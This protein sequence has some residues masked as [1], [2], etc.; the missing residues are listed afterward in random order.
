MLV[1]GLVNGTAV[2]FQVAAINAVGTG[3]FSALSNSVTPTTAAPVLTVPG[4]PGIGTAVAGNASATVNWTAPA[5]TGGS[6]ITGYSVRVVNAAN[7]QVGA[8]RPA[9]AGSTSLVVTV[10]NGTAVRFQ[11]AAV[12]AVGTGLFSAL[13]NAV[14]PVAPATVPGAP[15]IR[16]PARGGGGAPIT[17][18]A[19]WTPG[20]TGGSPITSYTV[21]ALTLSSAAANA[22]VVATQV[23]I[24]PGT[25]RAVTFTFT[26]PG[27][28]VRFVVKASNAIGTG[29]SSAQ[30]AVVTPR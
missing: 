20:A 4:T 25:A 13:S 26:Q 16:A 24:A 15:S 11:V 3:L 23:S 30:S 8:L 22:T 27:L 7:A 5:I 18:T 29:P 14:T 6:A 10:A 17:A 28:I 21:T 9:P 12:N 1:T 2:R 19:N